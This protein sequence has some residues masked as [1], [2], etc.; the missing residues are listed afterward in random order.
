VA[1][2][3]SFRGAPEVPL[4]LIEVFALTE[5]ASAPSRGESQEPRRPVRA[6]ARPAAPA[7]SRPVAR[8]PEVVTPAVAPALAA[9]TPGTRPV[10]AA[11]VST[12]PAVAL[13]PVVEAPPAAPGSVRG[14]GQPGAGGSSSGS[15]SST[16]PAGGYQVRPAYPDVARRMG[17]EGTTL[18]RIRILE[19][20]AVGEVLVARSA[21]HP[22]LDEAAVEAV[23]RWR[24]EPAKRDGRPIQ[25]WA[26]LPIRFRL[27]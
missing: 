17:A 19:D 9:P 8:A 18:L 24:F 3:W 10:D 2:L 5:A 22:S 4:R 20:G 7:P 26:S 13:A 11:P 16:L 14:N 21:G 25:V 23:R 12:A 6:E 1:V 27:E 15:D